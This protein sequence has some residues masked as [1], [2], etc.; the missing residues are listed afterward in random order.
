MVIIRLNGGLGNQLFQY[1]VGHA[2]ARKNADI[3]KLDLNAYKLQGVAKEEI[4][5][6]EILKYNVNAEIATPDE[7]NELKYP[8]GILS[9]GARFIE[10]RLFKKYYSD[11]HPEILEQKGDVYLDGYFQCEKY[12]LVE[13][14]SLLPQLILKNELNTRFK[15]YEENISQMSNSLSLHIRRG[16]YV[17]VPKFKKFH[18]ICTINYYKMALS[19]ASSKID[20]FSL[21][22][23]SD[24]IGWVK[25][26]LKLQGDVLYVSSIQTDVNKFSAAEELLLMAKCKHHIISNSTF[27]WWGAYLN[28]YKEKIVFAPNLWNRSKINT[29]KNILPP[30]WISLPV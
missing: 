23:F 15:R 29:H 4:R 20:Q 25:D 22:V 13:L 24:D 5:G 7:I 27:S 26:N 19:A 8:K 12:F 28:P 2:L 21:V 17:T 10:Q 11:W 18:D 9:F 6:A 14:D 1:A 16:D 30:S 3:L